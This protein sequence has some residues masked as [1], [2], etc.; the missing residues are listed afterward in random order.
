M[1]IFQSTKRK[2]EIL[3]FWRVRC[4]L[5]DSKMKVFARNELRQTVLLKLF[6]LVRN[7]LINQLLTL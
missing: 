6:S 1:G 3:C 5:F 7:T 4:K 2:P